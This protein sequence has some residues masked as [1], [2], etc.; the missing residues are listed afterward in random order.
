MINT[1]Y[2]CV[3]PSTFRIGDE[4]VTFTNVR[5][6]AFMLGD[7]LSPTGAAPV[8]GPGAF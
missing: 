2:S 1:T 3:S 7:D 4:A 6:Q 8:L 5:L